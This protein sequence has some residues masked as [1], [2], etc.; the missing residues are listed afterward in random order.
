[1]TVPELCVYT[2]NFFDRYDDPTFIQNIKKY[3]LFR[4]IRTDEKCR[5]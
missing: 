4:V 2:R 5:E 3:L 1:M